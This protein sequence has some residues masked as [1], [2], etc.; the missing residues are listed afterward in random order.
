M[1][2]KILLALA[3]AIVAHILLHIQVATVP[4]NFCLNTNKEFSIYVCESVFK[5]VK[6]HRKWQTARKKSHIL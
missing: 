2:M 5:C 6:G 4:V 3:R 1:E